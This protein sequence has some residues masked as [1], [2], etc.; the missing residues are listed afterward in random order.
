MIDIR[1]FL[2]RQKTEQKADATDAPPQ[3]KE[4]PASSPA[5]QVISPWAGLRYLGLPDE[6]LPDEPAF[7]L[8]KQNH[9]E[10]CG[11]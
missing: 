8:T 11:S 2:D 7:D 1:Y 4:A 3:P 5:R 9:L 6:P 10:G